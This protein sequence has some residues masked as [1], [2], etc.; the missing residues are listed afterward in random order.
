LKRQ[1]GI[2]ALI[3]MMAF[4]YSAS[5]SAYELYEVDSVVQDYAQLNLATYNKKLK[6]GDTV[7]EWEVI[8]THNMEGRGFSAVLWKDEVDTPT[9]K[10]ESSADPYV[11]TFRG[12]NDWEDAVTDITSVVM[13]LTDKQVRSAINFVRKH[14]SKN[15]RTLVITGH[16]LGGYLA[17]FVAASCFDGEMGKRGCNSQPG[18]TTTF[19]APGFT[20]AKWP[21]KT[22]HSKAIDVKLENNKRGRYNEYIENHNVIGDLVSLS[23]TRLG[24]SRGYSPISGTNNPVDWHHLNEFIKRRGF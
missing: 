4:S 18:Y 10:D 15:M 3:F 16:S 1:L 24:I 13:G 22:A 7:E 9:E 21:F 17:Q 8:D 23:G 11:I 6:K 5:A 19:N 12:T 20:S 2:I 14:D